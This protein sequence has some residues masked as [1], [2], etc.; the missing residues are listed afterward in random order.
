MP[1]GS[2]APLGEG[3]RGVATAAGERS[4]FREG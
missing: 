4:L 1:H 3:T 2:T